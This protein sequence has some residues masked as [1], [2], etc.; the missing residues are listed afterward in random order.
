M[1]SPGM[2]ITTM[3]APHRGPR[4][5]DMSAL[6]R[7]HVEPR[8]STRTV[9]EENQE[10]PENEIKY[11]VHKEPVSVVTQGGRT[12]IGEVPPPMSP[13]PLLRTLHMLCVTLATNG[14]GAMAVFSSFAVSPP[15]SVPF[16][17]QFVPCA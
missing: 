9:K 11:R 17:C 5:H 14:P 2:Q 15:V 6:V 4:R 16:S 3:V 7:S 12:G 13:T 1:K 8:P 10:A